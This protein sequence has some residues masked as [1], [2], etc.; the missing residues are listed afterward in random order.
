MNKI[1]LKFGE[2]E[3]TAKFGL[4]TIGNLLKQEDI[5]LQDF[6]SMFEKN[7]AYVAPKLLFHA[8][9]KGDPS[10]EITEEKVE[11]MIDEDGGFQSPQLAVFLN[12][13]AAS[14]QTDDVGKSNPNPATRKPKK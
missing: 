8:I 5:S 6:F 10:K 7:I 14:I 11:D 1:I 9:K 2:L 13:F 3:F 12:A 4:A